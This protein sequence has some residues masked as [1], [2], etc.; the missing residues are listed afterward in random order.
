MFRLFVVGVGL[1]FFLTS[2]GRLTSAVIDDR[3][4]PVGNGESEGADGESD[5]SIEDGFFGFF[6]FGCI[7]S[8]GHVIVTADENKNN[9]DEAADTNDSVEDV[10]DSFR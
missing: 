8:G 9:C 2:I 3:N 5:A 10:G 7:T 6:E 1:F 4:G